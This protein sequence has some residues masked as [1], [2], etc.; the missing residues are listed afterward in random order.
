MDT[1]AAATYAV[2]DFDAISDADSD[3]VAD[4]DADAVSDAD[5]DWTQVE[6][7]LHMVSTLQAEA[8]ERLT[9]LTSR[10]SY[11]PSQAVLSMIQSCH[12]KSMGELEKTGEVTFGQMLLQGYKMNI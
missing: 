10:I 11:E 4:S 6:E 8:Y 9:V 3:A 1:S 12:E 2:N 5:I 7:D